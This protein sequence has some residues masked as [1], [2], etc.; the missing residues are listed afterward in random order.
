MGTWLFAS[1]VMLIHTR[2]RAYPA[3]ALRFAGVGIQSEPRPQGKQEIQG[4]FFF[5]LDHPRSCTGTEKGNYDET[6]VCILGWQARDP[7]L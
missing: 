6:R 3:G 7:P 5:F 2:L 1:P 4:V